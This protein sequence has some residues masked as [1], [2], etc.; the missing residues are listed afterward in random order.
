MQTIEQ[1][2]WKMCMYVCV[3]MCVFGRW[4]DCVDE[5]IRRTLSVEVTFKHRP[6]DNKE[7]P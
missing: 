1:I 7:D 2:K 5:V 6:A 3:C 4:G